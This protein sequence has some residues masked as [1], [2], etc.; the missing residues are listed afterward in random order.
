MA[1]L[2]TASLSTAQP[3]AAGHSLMWPTSAFHSAQSTAGAHSDFLQG[4]SLH[5]LP[6]TVSS[7]P[8]AAPMGW[9]VN[10]VPCAQPSCPLLSAVPTIPVNPTLSLP[11]SSHPLLGTPL[12]TGTNLNSNVMPISLCI[13]RV[14]NASW[15][16]YIPLDQLTNAACYQALTTSSKQ[17][18]SALSL[19]LSGKLQV[20]VA[21]FDPSK[22]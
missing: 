2:T 8:Q 3:T 18:D 1:Q 9:G 14:F 12:I 19:S 20:L 10:E 17:D 4:G 6:T 22:E 7:A 16:S 11:A 5:V 21:H 13:E 15:T